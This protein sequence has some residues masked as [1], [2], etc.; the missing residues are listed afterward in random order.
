MSG[1]PGAP[2]V[3]HV[4]GSLAAGNPLAQRCA[5]VIEAFGG[6]LRHF[7]VAADGDFGA[8]DG[9]SRGVP[10]HRVAD[11]PALDGL[12]L[13]G[14]LQRIARAMQDYHL[15]L[16]HGW[17][18]IDAA[19]AHTLF[20]EH[21][22]LPPL[23]HHEDGS[24][25]TPAQRRGLRR[26]WYRRLGLGKAA[27]LVVPTETMEGVALTRWEQP[28][29]RVKL[30]R[31][32]V[33]LRRSARPARA[34]AIPRLLKRPGEHWIGCFAIPFDAAAFDA[35]L[36][37]MGRLEDKWQVVAVVDGRHRDVAAAATARRSFDHRVRFLP[38]QADRAAAMALFDIVMVAGAGEPL[39]L[40]AV[41][42]MAAGKPVLGLEPAEAAASLS[43]DNVMVG[44]DPLGRLAGDSFLRGKVGA[45]NRETAEAERDEQV[46]IAAYRRLYASAM[47]RDAI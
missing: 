27:G 43:A 24:D 18:A 37:A 16:T 3:L 34:D 36:A 28:L 11:F 10:I 42:A 44:D 40:P 15:V 1:K 46:M 2:R 33:D 32:G 31:D 17:G 20:S 22:R 26:T 25:E 29:G 41:E 19:L 38:E 6:R 23:I 12:P 4:H 13:P 45:A 5:R 35:M 7:V 8:L 47:G 21:L 9:L 39:P 14:R 30:I